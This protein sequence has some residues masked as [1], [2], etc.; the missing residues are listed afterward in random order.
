[1]GR[2]D[3]NWYVDGFV[4]TG[5]CPPIPIHRCKLGEDSNGAVWL[6]ESRFY[7]KKCKYLVKFDIDNGKDAPFLRRDVTYAPSYWEAVKNVYSAKW[8]D[9]EEIQDEIMAFIKIH[10]IKCKDVCGKEVMA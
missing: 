1:M 7:D 6:C 4:S 10:G 5:S 3:L 8:C 9:Y 2:L